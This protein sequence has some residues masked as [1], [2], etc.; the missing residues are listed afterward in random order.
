MTPSQEKAIYAVKPGSTVLMYDKLT[1]GI[2]VG[3]YKRPPFVKKNPNKMEYYIM[4]T[5]A[6]KIRTITTCH[7]HIWVTNVFS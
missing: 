1:I 7:P 2:I 4:Y 5:R 3:K 6:G